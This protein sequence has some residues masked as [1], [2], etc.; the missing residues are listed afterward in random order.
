MEREIIKQEEN[1]DPDYWEKLLRHHYEQQQEDLA[2]H[3][4]KGKRI[5]KQVNYNDASQEDQGARARRRRLRPGPGR[6]L[7]ARAGGRVGWGGGRWWLEVGESCGWGTPAWT[8]LGCS[9]ARGC[10]HARVPLAAHVH[11][12][13]GRCGCS[14]TLLM[15]RALCR[16]QSGRTSFRT[17][18]PNTPSGPR[19]RMRTLRRDRKDRVSQHWGPGWVISGSPSWG[20]HHLGVSCRLFG[21]GLCLGYPAGLFAG[22]RRQSRRQ[23]KS[24]RDKPL[25]PLLARVGGN[26]E[27]RGGPQLILWAV[28]GPPAL[29]TPFLSLLSPLSCLPVCACDFPDSLSDLPVPADTPPHS[30]PCPCP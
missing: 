9:M 20:S 5:R 6:T 1:V 7:A 15:L 25:P 28:M 29:L 21:G 12:I 10:L 30:D 16:P 14:D 11:P 27:V 24:D 22:G 26:I 23:L 17:T 4:G 3:L 18:S 19:M 8:D 13:V 2:R